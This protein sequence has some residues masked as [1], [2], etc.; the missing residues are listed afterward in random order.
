MWAIAV[1]YAAAVAMPDPL[2]HYAWPGIELCPCSNLSHC[3]TAGMPREKSCL[4]LS[5][6]EILDFNRI[7]FLFPPP[8]WYLLLGSCLRSFFLFCIFK[9]VSSL[10]YGS[11]NLNGTH[12]CRRG[13]WRDLSCVLHSVSYFSQCHLLHSLWYPASKM[14]TSNSFAA[15]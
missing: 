15:S 4:S 1:I 8:R 3:T 6:G 11:F 14:A 2:I 9:V 5:T 7:M 10:V 12:C 13:W